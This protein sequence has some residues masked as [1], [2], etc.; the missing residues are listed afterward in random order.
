MAQHDLSAA[1]E[2]HLVVRVAPRH[3]VLDVIS[4]LPQLTHVVEVAADADKE[5]V[6]AGE[7]GR[8]LRKVAQDDAVVECPRGLVLEPAQQ[9]LVELGQF[10]ELNPGGNAEESPQRNEGPRRQY[11]GDSAV[12]RRRQAHPRKVHDLPVEVQEPGGN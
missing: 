12:Q 4:R 6:G 11:S 10:H 1:P 9:R 7:V 5:G 2:V 3:L 8:S